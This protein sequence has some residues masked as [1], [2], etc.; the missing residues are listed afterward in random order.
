L[1]L[2]V[3][4]QGV[5]NVGILVLMLV[6]RREWALASLCWSELLNARTANRL[7]RF[8][9]FTPPE[10]TDVRAL[11]NTILPETETPGAEAGWGRSI[12]SMRRWPAMIAISANSIAKGLADIGARSRQTFP[13]SATFAALTSAQQIALLKTIEKTDFF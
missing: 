10:A 3:K 2:K 4:P 11:T 5:F 7:S 9:V 12:L 8:A 6:S 13:P 1:R